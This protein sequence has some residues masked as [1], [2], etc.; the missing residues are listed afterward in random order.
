[1][2]VYSLALTGGS[3]MIFILILSGV[4]KTALVLCINAMKLM[5]SYILILWISCCWMLAAPLALTIIGS[6]LLASL[7]AILLCS[8][9]TLMPG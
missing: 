8:E 5:C 4:I 9:Q 6:I 2:F 1:M 7:L 3:I